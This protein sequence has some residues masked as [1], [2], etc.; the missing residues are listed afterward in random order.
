MIAT[1]AALCL[2]LIKLF[3]YMVKSDT[4]NRYNGLI[5]RCEDLCG[6]G[7]IAIT[8]NA[9]LYS[10]FIG[11]LNQWNLTGAGIA[12][13]SW[14]G[15]DFDDKSY[16]TKPSGTFA[17][18]LNRDYNFDESYKL[19][20]IKIVNVTYDGINWYAA[21]PIDMTDMSLMGNGVYNN[22]DNF[23]L[24][25]KDP[26]V[27][28]NFNP[29]RPKYDER[30]DGFDLYP[31]FTQANLNT[32]IANG[33]SCQVYVEWFRG[34][35]VFDTTS[36]TD[37]QEPS[38]DLQFHHFPA[39]GA[40]FEYAKLFKPELA[41]VLQGDLYGARTARGQ[42]IRSGI[43]DDMKDW[44]ISKNRLAPSLKMKRSIKI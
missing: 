19:M 39:I 6:L 4:T 2:S 32:A 5:Q 44:Y 30:S 40:S 37:T 24:A 43:I 3:S 20:K 21:T 42:L 15:A 33:S 8:S 7:A 41:A 16:T 14:G 1:T 22:T 18:T 31:K 11:W 13:M 26:N 29:T 38:M 10:Q 28:T 35:N 34:P 12:I 25:T 17:G 27:D 23:L 9:A 36:G